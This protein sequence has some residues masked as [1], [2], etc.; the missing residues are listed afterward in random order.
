MKVEPADESDFDAFSSLRNRQIPEGAFI[1]D[2]L[3]VARRMLAGPLT[4]DRILL[5]Q[6]WL[7]MF[8]AEIEARPETQLRVRLAPQSKLAEIVGFDLHQGIMIMGRMPRVPT[9]A[10]VL[11]GKKAPLLLAMDGLADAENV[12]A[13]MRTCAAFG[14]DGVIVGA[15][16]CSPWTRRAVRTS[17]GAVLRVP[18]CESDNLAATLRSLDGVACY[19]AHIH[20]EHRVITK[21]DYSG[22][23]CI[24]VGGEADGVSAPVLAAC[25]STIFIP[26]AG[27]WDCLNVGAATAVLLYEATRARML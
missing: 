23:T 16:T 21:V 14:V 27:G 8:R 9:I 17:L 22:P 4:L 1:G 12:G 6:K 18:V 24:V 5:S 13:V 3:K 10:S 15:G 20:G 19:A 2:G 25:R 7:D 11:A 26:M